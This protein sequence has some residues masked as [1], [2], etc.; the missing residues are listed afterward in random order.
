[1]EKISIAG[2]AELLAVL[3]YH[4]GF[5]PR[6]S[7]LVACFT[8]RRMEL[9]VRL[10]VVPPGRAAAAAAEVIP[11]VLDAAPDWAFVVGY[12]DVVG[13]CRPLSE[14]LAAALGLEGIGVA[15]R[16]TV[17]GGRWFCLTC[18]ECPPEGA[19]LPE[20]AD[21][22]GVAGYVGL[23]RAVLPRREALGDLVEPLSGKD[24]RAAPL[25]R[26]IEAWVLALAAARAA[27]LEPMVGGDIDDWGGDLDDAGDGADDGYEE[28]GYREDDGYGDWTP[29]GAERLVDE[30]LGTWG[31][32]LDG[33]LDEVLAPAGL[34]RSPSGE[35]GSPPSGRG[36]DVAG[37]A[38]SVLAGSLRDHR[39]RDALIAWLCPGMLSLELLEPDIVA[40]LQEFLGPR[41]PAAGCWDGTV[42]QGRARGGGGSGEWH[43]DA[44]PDLVA[45]RLEA[46]VRCVPAE[47]AT[48]VLALVAS[49]AWW[50]GDGARA[51]V[52]LDRALELEPEHRLCLLLR[53]MVAQGIR[54]PARSA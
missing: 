52:A 36:S 2:P 34:R 50:R 7:V 14:A 46:L 38:L 12:E 11:P 35:I 1:M 31:L 25:A 49:H 54:L 28:D 8:G 44:L 19:P 21:V 29:S 48:P 53:K 39:L 16:V 15:G 30:A 5:Q 18:D 27:P 22:P 10:D 51:G 42:G 43:A 9:V 6:R 26:R 23:G 3:P 32:L 4:L 24:P 41:P 40:G 33:G 37:T 17:R 47:H 13:E 45:A 20:D